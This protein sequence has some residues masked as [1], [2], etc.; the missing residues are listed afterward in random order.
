MD[1][2]RL[3]RG[4]KIA[5]VSAIALLLIMFIFSWFGIDAEG[6]VD[7][8]GAN[9]WESFGLIDLILFITVVAAIALAAMLA[10]G[11]RVDMPVSPAAIVAGLGIL[12]V[13][14]ILF[15]IISPPD[16][17]LGDLLEIGGGEVSRKIGVFLGLIA[18]A[19]IA[20]GGYESMQEEGTSFAA[21][22]DRL[23]DRDSAPGET[24]PP[25]DPA[26]PGGPPP[27]V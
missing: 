4:E 24:P 5:A 15:R 6:G 8:G 1:V 25:R 9:A 14:L 23:S 7:L 19:G 16:F 10:N 11:Q 20:Y 17:G 3:G 27:A 21:E 22:R 18:A 2:N 13:I 12:S 26:G